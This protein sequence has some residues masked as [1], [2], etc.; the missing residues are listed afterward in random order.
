MKN[1]GYKIPSKNPKSPY[2]NPATGKGSTKKAAPL[3]V[4]QISTEKKAKRF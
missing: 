3:T 2:N 1:T 4:N